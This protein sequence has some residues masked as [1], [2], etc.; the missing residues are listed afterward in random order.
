MSTT[1][2]PEPMDILKDT[3][4]KNSLCHSVGRDMF[5]RYCDEL[6]DWRRA[7]EISAWK[8]HRCALV[9]VMCTTCFDGSKSAIADVLKDYRITIIDGRELLKKGVR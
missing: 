8:G 1:T 7:V 2:T 3:L 5:C 4:S 6:M 9:K